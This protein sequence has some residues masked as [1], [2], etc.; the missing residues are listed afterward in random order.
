[1]RTLLPSNKASVASARSVAFVARPCGLRAP[2]PRRSAAVP[3]PAGTNDAAVQGAHPT[4]MSLISQT[5]AWQRLGQIVEER[6][7]AR[8][9]L[10]TLVNRG[11]MAEILD[12]LL[13]SPAASAQMAADP[14]LRAT[15]EGA[16]A[17]F[18]STLSEDDLLWLADLMG[19]V[20]TFSESIDG[21]EHYPAK[22]LPGAWEAALRQFG[23]APSPGAA[24]L[25]AAARS[26]WTPARVDSFLE[27]SRGKITPESADAVRAMVDRLHA[28]QD[29]RTAALQTMDILELALPPAE[30]WA[31]AAGRDQG[32]PPLDFHDFLEDDFI[33]RMRE[34]IAP[35]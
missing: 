19:H 2:A 17:S 24:Q 29:V 27:E 21:H 26:F 32:A 35:C 20:H 31:I 4:L 6:H 25:L 13:C 18:D 7:F 22:G 11:P 16:V 15:V 30:L 5:R 12:T 10:L 3:R 28:Q 8:D 9:E 23:R 14:A 1:M 33:D 34:H